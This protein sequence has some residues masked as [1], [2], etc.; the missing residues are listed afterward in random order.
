MV[1]LRGGAAG[2]V[3]AAWI[4]GKYMADAAGW[5]PTGAAAVGAAVLVGALV[6]NAVGL[7]MSGRVQLLLGG[8]LAA[9]LLCTVLAAAP[10]CPRTTSPRSCPA[11]GRR[12]GRRPRC[13]SSRSPA[14][15]RPATSRASSPIRPG[16]CR[17]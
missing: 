13:C 3:S 7:R 16:T 17:G 9:V 4:G 2:V 6:S 11:V 14:G 10:G 5:G 8:L 15:R 12:W 1:V